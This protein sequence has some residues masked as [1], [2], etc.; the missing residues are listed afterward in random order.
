MIVF[1]SRPKAPGCWLAA[2]FA[3]CAVL[4]LAAHALSP[5]GASL[6]PAAQLSPESAS[7]CTF[8]MTA[9]A[10]DRGAG[11]R[12]AGELSAAIEHAV[13]AQDRRA[14]LVVRAHPDAQ[15]N[16]VMLLGKVTAPAAIDY[17]ALVRSVSLE[18]PNRKA[19]ERR[20]AGVGWCGPARLAV[21]QSRGTAGD[22]SGQAPRPPNEIIV[23]KRACQLF[24]SALTKPPTHK[25]KLLQIAL[26]HEEFA[27]SIAAWGCSSRLRATAD[28]TLGSS[29]TGSQSEV[30]C[31]LRLLSNDDRGGS[32]RAVRRLERRNEKNLTIA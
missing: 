15:A 7:G 9:D 18:M 28:S 17:N 27:G 23:A 14:R 20:R 25:P 1:G 29:P 6:E 11:G 8:L 31:G 5:R 32:E 16:V 19:H 3:T 24:P 30:S 2:C 26:I 4:A 22:P 12:L 21:G 13:L 10:S